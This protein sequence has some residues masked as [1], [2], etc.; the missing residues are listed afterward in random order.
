VFGADGRP[1]AQA[2]LPREGLFDARLD[3]VGDTAWCVPASWFARGAAGCAWLPADGGEAHTVFVYDVSR[4]AWSA[5][6]RFPDAVADFS[7]HPGGA[8]ALVTCWDGRAYLVGRDGT[9]HAETDLGGP[10]RLRWSADGDFAIAGTEAGEVFCL[11]R[12]A[13]VRWNTALPVA[14]VPRLGKPLK[15]VFEEVPVYSVGRVGPE[16][17]YVGDTWLIKTGQGGILVDAGGTSGIPLTLEKVRAAGLDPGDIRFLLLSH[18]HGDHANAA[19]LWRARGA[20]VVA[21][22]SAAFATAWVNTQWTGYGVSVPIPIDRP[23]PMRRAGDE[24]EITL[25]GVPI[26]AV[27]V[28]GHSIDSV[29]YFME[30][31]G[32]RVIFSG[33][34]AFD[35]AR[36]GMPLGSNILHRCWADRDKAAAVIRVIEEKVLPLKPEFEFKGHASSRDPAGSWGNILD[37]SRRALKAGEASGSVP[38]PK[39]R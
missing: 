16:H 39:S 12:D 4:Q 28:P 26:K 19:Y 13:K 5:A 35:D 3:P 9:V 6:W 8:R 18:S 20:E 32:R 31:N 1:V 23:I 10:A 11:D 33:D 27:F 36:A 34:I 22:A 2:E 15:P 30:L 38:A 29:V 17:A 25:C 21:P 7:I 37:A 14:D 24:A